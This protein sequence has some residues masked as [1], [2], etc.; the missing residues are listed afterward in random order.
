VKLTFLGT[1]TSFGVPQLVCGCAVCR[2]TEPR[3][4]RTRVGAA[5]DTAGGAATDADLD[6]LIRGRDT[7]TV[8]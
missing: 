1:G 8:A 3:D 5:V 6:A 4:K 7:W 2:S